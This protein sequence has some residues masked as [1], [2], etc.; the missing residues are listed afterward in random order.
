MFERFTAELSDKELIVNDGR[1]IDAE[2]IEAPQRRVKHPA[3]HTSDATEHDDPSTQEIHR[4]RQVDKDAN[5]TKRRGRFFFGYS[6]T[7]KI[8]NGSKCVLTFHATPASVHDSQSLGRVL[9]PEQDSGQEVY[10]DKGYW[11]EPCEK[12][13]TEIA[14]KGKSRILHKGTRDNPISDEQKRENTQWSKIRCRVE[15]VFAHRKGA[16]RFRQVRRKGLK[17]ARFEIGLGDVV[18]NMQRMCF[19][20]NRLQSG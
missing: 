2:I 1:I 11:G 6:H 15:H 14:G 7:I 8:D 16:L 3:E 9:N 13:V 20:I 5:K 4:D 17:R 19:L 18:Y 12:V 10:A